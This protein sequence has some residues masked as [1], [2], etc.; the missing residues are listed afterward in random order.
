MTDPV[1]LAQRVEALRWLHAQ[2]AHD[3]ALLTWRSDHATRWPGLRPGPDFCAEDWPP[4]AVAGR[5]GPPDEKLVDAELATGQG[6]PPE[7]EKLLCCR[8]R[9]AAIE[10]PHASIVRG[11]HEHVRGC[12]ESGCLK[13]CAP[14]LRRVSHPRT[15]CGLRNRLLPG[16]ANRKDRTMSNG[17]SGR[18]PSRPAL[19]PSTTYAPGPLR[20]ALAYIVTGSLPPLP[21]RADLARLAVP[22]VAGLLGFLAGVLA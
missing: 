12:R 11:A 7:P 13:S 6:S 18:A 16:N 9:N 8:K 21:L 2:A 22:A 17:V 4:P 20:R 15:A 19:A 5:K 14:D 1:I 3:R 10:R